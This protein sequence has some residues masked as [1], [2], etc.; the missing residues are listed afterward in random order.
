MT[1]LVKWAVK[2]ESLRKA[3]EAGLPLPWT[4][5]VILQ[6]YRFCNIRRR[7]DRVSR[8]LRQHVLTGDNL[9]QAG[10]QSFILF[11]AFCRW[12]NWP[13]TIAAIMERGLFPTRQIDWWAIAGVMDELKAQKR[14]IFTGAFMIK[15]NPKSSMRTKSQWICTQVIGTDLYIQLPKIIEAIST[16]TR[17]NV[18]QEFTKVNNFGSFMSGQVVD[19]LGWTVLLSGAKDVNTWCPTGPGSI[20]GFNRLL[21]RPITAKI[22]EAEW[23]SVLQQWRRELIE[24][25]GAEY[26]NCTLHDIQNCCCEWFKYSKVLLGEGRPR[27]KYRPEEAY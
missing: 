22:D 12:C 14:K 11:A 7:D 5:D 6:I 20:R 10:M 13:P 9:S 24:V 16:N 27:S 8:W 4:D 19:D 21:G 2:R 17:R 25:L 3:K 15:A 1:P 26:N 18:W 23:C